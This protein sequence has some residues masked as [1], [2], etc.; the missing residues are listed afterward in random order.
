MTME[1][2]ST[3]ANWINSDSLDWLYIGISVM[4]GIRRK[5]G[6]R[7]DDPRLVHRR[8]RTDHRRRPALYRPGRLHLRGPRQCLGVDVL[9]DVRHL[10]ASNGDGEDPVVLERLIRGFDLP[11]GG[12]DH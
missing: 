8:P 7:G 4:V 3:R 10:A 6:V 5:R 9:P 2:A 12:A 11:R 1:P